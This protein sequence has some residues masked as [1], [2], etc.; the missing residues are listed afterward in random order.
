VL[1]AFAAGQLLRPLAA[2]DGPNGDVAT[3]ARELGD[4]DANMRLAQCRRSMGDVTS[5]D[6]ELSAVDELRAAP[7]AVK[8][9]A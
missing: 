7:Q 1:L 5:T 6:H 9:I 8:R 2:Q 3:Y 4:D